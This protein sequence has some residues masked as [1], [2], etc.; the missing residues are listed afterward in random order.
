MTEETR[1]EMAD[2]RAKADKFG[3]GYAVMSEA[4]SGKGVDRLVGGVKLFLAATAALVVLGA[5][6]SKF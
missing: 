5:V 3:P 4:L 1:D 2:L 6:F